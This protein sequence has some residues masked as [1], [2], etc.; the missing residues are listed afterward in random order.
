MDDKQE[1]AEGSLGRSLTRID[2]HQTKTIVVN[3]RELPFAGEEIGRNEL[4]RLA[5]P[6]IGTGGQSSLTVA[7]DHGAAEAPSGL[8]TAGRTTRVL[9]GQTFSVSL[10]DKS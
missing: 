2:Q 4:A 10:T 5:F 9:E 1:K 7:Y 3:G 8:L 6:N